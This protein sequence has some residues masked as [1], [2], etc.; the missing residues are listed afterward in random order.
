MVFCPKLNPRYGFFVCFAATSRAEPRQVKDTLLSSD[1]V[2]IC[3][4]HKPSLGASCTELILVRGLAL[5][6][7]V[8]QA[9][10][11]EQ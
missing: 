2:T 1:V 6:H 9:V 8:A 11:Q 4:A 3:K 10:N 5:M 7:Q